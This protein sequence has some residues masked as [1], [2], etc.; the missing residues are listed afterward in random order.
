MPCFQPVLASAGYDYSFLNGTAPGALGRRVRDQIRL[1]RIANLAPSSSDPSLSKPEPGQAGYSEY[2]DKRRHAR[3]MGLTVVVGRN[4]FKEYLWGLK[5][6]WLADFDAVQE[7]RG[8][9]GRL[10]D[11]REELDRDGVFDDRSASQVLMPDVDDDNDGLHSPPD[12]SMEQSTSELP[13]SA[14]LPPRSAFSMFSSSSSSSSPQAGGPSSLTTTQQQKEQQR[15][16]VVNAVAEL[17]EQPPLLVLPFDHPIGYLRHWPIKMF[18]YLFLERYRVQRGCETALAII[19]ATH[20]EPSSSSSASSSSSMSFTPDSHQKGFRG[21]QPPRRM[22]QVDTSQDGQ[23]ALDDIVTEN[24][25]KLLPEWS[26]E[27]LP[28][29]GSEDLDRDLDSERHYR[30]TFNDTPVNIISNRKNFYDELPEKL[31]VARELENRERLPTKEEQ[32]YP[33][34]TEDELKRDR[35]NKEKKWRNDLQGWLMTRRGSKVT[36]DARLENL[37]VLDVDLAKR[38]IERDGFVA[39]RWQEDNHDQR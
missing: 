35:L 29:S 20:P 37:K 24:K 14:L 39:D 6:G 7:E 2:L 12:V 21:I 16:L 9:E 26:G 8:E 31:K 1:E 36:W 22:D 18:K 30:K 23:V 11:L 5:Q 33:P 28:E 25:K 13:P 15:S 17:P 38:S 3:A 10:Q 27:D 32:K 34:P 19:Q 4:T